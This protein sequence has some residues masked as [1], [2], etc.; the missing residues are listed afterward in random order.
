MRKGIFRL[1][2]VFLLLLFWGRLVATAV[3]LSAT[4]DEPLHVLQGLFFWRQ[5]SL[6]SV[7]QNPP[8]VNALM[9]VPLRLAFH[10]LLP[11]EASGPVFQDWLK[12]SQQF[13]WQAN[14]NGLQMVFVGRLAVICLALLLGA[15][16]LRWAGQWFGRD[17]GL[18]TL[19]LYTFD[20][21]VLANASLA[22]T[23]LGTA[24]FMTLAAYA[25]WRYWTTQDAG[26]F[27][28]WRRY[29]L[30]GT[31][32]GLAFAS[33]FSGIILV[34]ALVLAAIWR[35][36]GRQKRTSW[37]HAFRELAGWL[38]IGTV[39]FLL[40]YRFDW[41][42]LQMDFSLQQTHQL[43]GHSSF[44]FG[45]VNVGGWWYY[46]PVLFAVKTPLAILLLVGLGLFLFVR[47]WPWS[48]PQV[49]VWLLVGG[50]AGASLISRVNI[51]YRYLLPIL[52]LLFVLFGGIWPELKSRG[53]LAIG[54][55]LL[56]VV[57]ESAWL[58]PHYL[59]YFNQLAG[60]P[61]QGWRVAVDSN[62]DWGQDLAA[63]ADFEHEH[64]PE[65]YQVAWLGSVPLAV[66]GVENGRPMPIWPHGREDP[67]TD[68]F[69]PPLPASGSYVLSATQLQGVYLKNR[70][71][72]AWFQEHEPSD[73]IGYSL[74]V[75]DVPAAGPAV[76]LGLSGIGPAMIAS[77]DYTAAFQSNDVR[78]RWFD[79]RTSLLWPAGGSEEVWTAVGAGHLPQNPLLNSLYPESG[80]V[81][82]GSQVL[83]G[84]T[85]QYGLYQ[86]DLSFFA[87]LLEQPEVTADFGWSAEPVVGAATWSEK[88]LALAEKP[89]FEETF[90][91]SG[92]QVEVTEE[93][94]TLL[95]Y[96]NVQQPPQDEVKIFVHLLDASGQLISQ[97]DGLD[98]DWRW[99]QPGDAFAQLHVVSLPADL[100]PGTYALQLGL[101]HTDDGGRLP[102]AVADTTTDRVL[103]QT[104][105]IGQ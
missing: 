67:L 94:V 22:T 92:Y 4:F 17:A 61:S 79:A 57:V 31:A 43:E 84:Q 35:Q 74:F 76:G 98:V 91:L 24:V 77:G 6:L 41:T 10:P 1:T 9:G 39:V 53:R 34:P 101:Y 52:P 64:L 13:F 81:L 16:L 47:R 27:P 97:H 83:D 86:W 88:R 36:L 60:G 45:Q 5:R 65:P 25:V 66:Y 3:T 19:I 82:T 51:G 28:G 78:P 103:L 89:L 42:S 75:Y 7:V 32:V 44:L 30:V 102:L 29:L 85:W 71:R 87:E 49:W 63:L 33:K 73:R 26:K 56:W 14:D 48:W 69:Y 58:H 11:P 15:L 62:L 20:P 80:P 105:E 93:A 46:F 2:A 40:I 18:L 104:I 23:D 72:F 37:G 12:V 68:P 54:L 99:L 21:N 8:L 55:A 38:L 50:V 100:P 90:S 70:D 59:A 96:W 95:G